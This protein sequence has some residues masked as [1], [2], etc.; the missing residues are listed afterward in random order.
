MPDRDYITVTELNTYIGSVFDAE[1][2]LHNVPVIGEVSGRKVVNGNCYF[3]LKDEK[4]QIK[5]VYF[6]VYD[7]F[8]PSDGEQV[9]VRGIVDFYQPNGQISVKAYEVTRFGVGLMH[10]KLQELKEKLAAEGLFDESHK[11]PLP[12]FPVNVGI[13]T[14]VKGAALQDI[15][16]T[17]ITRHNSKQNL[18]VIDVRVQGENCVND[19]V[20]ALTH[21]NAYGFDVILLARAGGSF[22]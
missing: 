3:T 4:A 6:G 11:K 16:S 12:K 13:I 19:V 2:L 5:V 21:P 8:V 14:S 7:R 15:F 22:E 10:A 18:S 17:L 9:L 1:E 20:T